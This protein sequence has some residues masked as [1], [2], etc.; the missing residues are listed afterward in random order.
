MRLLF[1]LILLVSNGAAMALETARSLV[2]AGAPRLAL[3]RV[4]QLQPAD[5]GATRWAEWETLRQGLLAELNRND[6]ALKRAAALPADFP[7]SLLRQCLLVAIRAAVAAGQPAAARAHAARLLWQLDATQDE[8]R[9]ARLLVIESHL[10]ERQ[11]ETAFRAMLRF[12]QDY[13]PVGRAVAGRFVESL[14]DLG[15]EKEAINWL[16]AL[17]DTGPLKLRLRL[18]A[19]LVSADTAVVQARPRIAGR[20]AAGYWR[21]LADAA[22]KLNDG[23]LRVEAAE[24]LLNTGDDADARAP[25]AAAL[26]QAYSTGAQAAANRNRLLTGDDGAWLDFASRRLGASPPQARALFA[27]LSRHGAARATRQAAQLRLV[28]SLRKG[29]LDRVAMRLFDQEHAPEA[30]DPQARYLLGSMAESRHLPA[31]AARH[32]QGLAAPPG[33]G[34]EEWQVRVAA[35]QWRAGM[36]EDALRAMRELAGRAKVLQAPAMERAVALAREMLEAGKPAPA[37]AL[38]SMLLP[39]AGRERARDVL[40]ALGGIAESGSRFAAAADYFL[41]AALVDGAQMTDAPALRARHAAAANLARAGY[42]E[43]ARAQYRWLVEH[44]KDPAQV[45]AARRELARLLYIG[46]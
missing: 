44:S 17:D 28:V 40:L 29:G 13:R 12:D 2:A 20:E 7:Q 30:L 43:D 37:E 38:Y 39:L 26:W 22:E 6:E 16:A 36:E 35:T 5:P 46:D 25:Q 21:V 32:W 15:L 45:A 4:E 1:V 11:S 27:H 3:S 19:G 9:A 33:T 8:A 31:V 24:Q 10:A 14:L 18:Q 41:R 34:D 42:R 23:A